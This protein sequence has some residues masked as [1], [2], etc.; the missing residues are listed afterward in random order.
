MRQNQVTGYDTDTTPS[1]PANAALN[2]ED[3]LPASLPPASPASRT[4]TLAGRKHKDDT[5]AIATTSS[6]IAD[7]SQSPP[8][9]RVYIFYL[10]PRSMFIPLCH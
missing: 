6:T 8:K 1:P 10:D 2:H 3:P 9:K 5:I 4:R 7:N